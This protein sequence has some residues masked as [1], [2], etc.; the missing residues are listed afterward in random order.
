MQLLATLAMTDTKKE[1]MYG[2]CSTSFLAEE[3]DNG[4][5][6]ASAAGNVK[7]RN[8]RENS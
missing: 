1:I 6:I 4:I 2:T 5:I 3:A 7:S 8:G